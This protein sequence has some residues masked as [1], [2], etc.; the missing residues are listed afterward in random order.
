MID[1]MGQSQRLLLKMLLEEK[2]GLTIDDMVKGLEISRTAVN[3][4]VAAL[5]N[6]SFIERHAL[7][8]TGGRPC[9]VYVLSEKGVELFPKQYSWFADLLLKYLE[10]RIGRDETE[11]LLRTMGE[12][13]AEQMRHRLTGKTPR[14]QLEEIAQIMQEL[15][16]EASAANVGEGELWLRAVNCIYHHLASE[17]PEVCSLDL[18]FLSAL[19]RRTVQHAECMVREGKACRFRLGVLLEDSQKSRYQKLE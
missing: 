14:E 3:Q 10:D 6:A 18:A 4:H 7:A 9:Q 12:D 16:Y 1:R 5:E 11:L 13:L 17:H 8:K 15:G 2:R 19:S